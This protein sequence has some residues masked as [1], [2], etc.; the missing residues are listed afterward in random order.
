MKRSDKI[1]Q[2]LRH[3]KALLAQQEESGRIDN[4]YETPIEVVA[5]ASQ[6]IETFEM[7]KAFII[8]ENPDG[9][10]DSSEAEL[11]EIDSESPEGG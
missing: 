11:T 4:K 7:A 10:S 8:D 9:G 5:M 6:V 3:S 1:K 2:L